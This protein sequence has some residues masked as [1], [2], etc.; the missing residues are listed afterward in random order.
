MPIQIVQKQREPDPLDKL[1]SAVNV[2]KNIYGMTVDSRNLDLAKQKLESDR[3][4]AK[5]KSE[6]DKKEKTQKGYLTENDLATG[7]YAV[8]AEPKEGYNKAYM[9]PQGEETPIVKY[10]KKPINAFADPYGA[11]AA[12]AEENKFDLEKKKR[13]LELS[14][15]SPIPGY[16]KT[17]ETPIDSTSMR[18]LKEAS[19]DVAKFNKNMDG[20]IK[21][22]QSAS[23]IEIANPLSN[24]S[25]AIKNDL[26]DLQLTYKGKAF[27]ELGVLA[28]PDLM[29]LDQILEDPGTL[30][31]IASGKEGVLERYKQARD[32]VNGGFSSKA[33]A[34]GLQNSSPK[35]ESINN[36]VNNED[37][38]AMD[39]ARQN[40]QD[41]RAI[42]ILKLHGM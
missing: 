23:K 17:D 20:L 4:L 28:G 39:W 37:K 18:Q 41:P 21:R 25:K 29:I 10:I 38:Q 15:K 22:V 12:S 9:L 1:V 34:Y 35:K 26:R 5:Q 13:D 24:T 30:S 19:A 2:I 14:K 27:A 36:S 33:S 8:S 11:K 3:E 31:N 7:G 32:R 16:V 6:S 40:P 42:E